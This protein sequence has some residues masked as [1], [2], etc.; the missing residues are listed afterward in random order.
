[1]KILFG[2]P[3]FPSTQYANTEQLA[4]DTINELRNAGFD[5]D[6]ICLTI[7]PPA[8]AKS[9]DEIE[10]LWIKGDKKLLNLYENIY[11]RCEN[12]DVFFNAAGIH[13]HRD[14]V[15]ELPCFT[16]FGCN[17]DPEASERLSKP[18]ADAYD[19]C[20]I[21]NIA[22]I[23]TYKSW[24]VKKVSWLPLGLMHNFYNKTL[25]END[26]LKGKRDIDIFFM[27]DKTS[28]YRRNRLL[29]LEKA[30]PNGSFWG[31]G[32]IKGYLP[33][34]QEMHFL[35]NTQLGINIH[36]STG[37]VNL[38]TFYLP[39]NGVLQLCDNKNNLGKIF[40]LDKEVIGFDSI[41]ECIEKC[42]YYLH[43][44]EEQRS[45]A[46]SGWKRVLKD[47]TYPNIFKNYFYIPVKE[48]LLQKKQRQH[49]HPNEIFSTRN[50]IRAAFKKKIIKKIIKIIFKKISNLLHLNIQVNQ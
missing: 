45:I 9:Y 4:F 50:R 8:Y 38:R 7:D 36:N 29:A 25:T 35:T 28:P 1:M 11:K 6:P 43:H 12:Y 32:W 49:M 26:I 2:Y 24:G 20:L 44:K 31:K 16:V 46:L 37:P 34:G 22:E 23:E 13:L 17:D 3:Y 15:K 14:F 47:Y 10:K 21:G 48:A 39:A 40:E 30:F 18:V 41:E 27:G 42:H 33:T 19:M 5:I